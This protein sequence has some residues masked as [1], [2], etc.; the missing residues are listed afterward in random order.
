MST[1]VD[2]IETTG[3]TWELEYTRDGEEAGKV[4]LSSLLIISV[5]YLRTN[6]TQILNIPLQMFF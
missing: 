1:Q 3:S 5:F 6:E 2:R 4:A